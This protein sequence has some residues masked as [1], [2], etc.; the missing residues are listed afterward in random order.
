MCVPRSIKMSTKK[1]LPKLLFLGPK[2]PPVGGMTLQTKMLVDALRLHQ[3]SIKWVATL[4]PLEPSWLNHIRGLRGVLKAASLLGNLLV[5]LPKCETIH[6]MANSGMSW[7]LYGL[8]SLLLAKFYG[9]KVIVNYRG[10]GAKAF[11]DKSPWLTV[12]MIRLADRVVVPSSYLK[13]IFETFDIKSLV[14]TNAINPEL[15]QVDRQTMTPFRAF[16]PRNLEK[17]YGNDLAIEALSFMVKQ[18]RPFYLDI[19][20]EGAELDALTRQVEQSGL[21][22]YV[23]FLGRLSREQMAKAYAKAHVVINPTRVDNMANALLEA[24]ACQCAIVSSD[25]GGNPTVI[26]HEQNGLLFPSDNAKELAL[27]I[28]RLMDSKSLRDKLSA[29][30][31]EESKAL[32]IHEVIKS[33]EQLYANL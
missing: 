20:G 13:K 22:D 21:Q 12:S 6:I 24:K 17:I 11:F 32:H 2:P 18:Q 31:F 7:Y 28:E 16:V 25:A 10:G 9:K 4:K 14:I 26:Q 15:F 29:K 8:P 23:H 5:E 1:R 33:W 27:S 30:A 19:A 3:H